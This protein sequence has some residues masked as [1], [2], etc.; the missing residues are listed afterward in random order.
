VLR[1]LLASSTFAIAGALNS[2]SE[3]LKRKLRRMEPVQSLEE[4]IE[5]DYEALNETADEW[6]EEP[7]EEPL[8]AADRAALEAEI[9]DLDTFARLATSIEHNAKGKALLEALGVAF[10]KTA[11][12]GGAQKAIIFTESR[13]TQNYLL[14]VLAD[15][16]FSE[17]IVLFNGSN[18][19]EH[20]KQIY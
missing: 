16:P 14:R 12:L 13:R 9:A 20:S 1:K 17:G 19:D 15:S 10:E 7:P 8:S 5:H 11:Q 2:I 18:T 3:R 6:P 4:E